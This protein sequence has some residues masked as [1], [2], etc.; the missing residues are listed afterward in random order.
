MANLEKISFENLGNLS[1][2]DVNRLY[3]KGEQIATTAMIELPTWVNYA[4]GIAA[5][6]TTAHVLT[7]LSIAWFGW[8]RIARKPSA[9]P[10]T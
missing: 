3:W 5:V 7:Q 9:K 4:V 6:V 2:D 10:R 8:P 1:V